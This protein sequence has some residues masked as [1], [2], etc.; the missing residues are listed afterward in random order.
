MQG[1]C[2][3]NTTILSDTYEYINYMFR[4][5]DDHRQVGYN[6]RGKLHKYNM[7]Q[8]KYYVVFFFLYH[9]AFM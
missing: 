7:V 3:P 4:P 6:I 8:N 2:R 5:D 1:Y 9:I